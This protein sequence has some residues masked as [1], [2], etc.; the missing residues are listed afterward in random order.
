GDLLA[1]PGQQAFRLLALLAADFVADAGPVLVR[2]AGQGA[3]QDHMAP[4][5]TGA[6]RGVGQGGA[7]LGTV[8]DD[9]EELPGHG[10]S[11]SLNSRRHLN[12]PRPKRQ[13]PPASPDDETD[14]P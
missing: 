4:G 10:P 1:Q 7:Q 9:D 5:R 6:A 12:R 11:G 2:S 13:G 8:V 3:Q 14:G